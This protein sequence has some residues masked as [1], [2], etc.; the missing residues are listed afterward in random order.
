M[1]YE[2]LKR[3]ARSRATAMK[4]ISAVIVLCF[5]LALS[6]LVRITPA[7]AVM[8]PTLFAFDAPNLGGPPS[9]YPAVVAVIAGASGN[10]YYVLRS[11]GEVDAFGAT[12][13]GSE[14]TGSLPTGT[15]ATGMTLDSATGG[16]WVV[17]SSGTVKGFNAPFLGEPRIP[18]GGWGQYPAAVAIAA[19]PTGDGYFILRANGAIDPYGVKGH[20]SLKG[21]LVYGAIAPVVAVALAVDPI[22][23]GYWIATSTG[24]VAN[25]DAPSEGSPFASSKGNYDGVPV[26]ALVANSSGT[27]YYVLR[28]NGAIDTY[29]ATSHGSPAAAQTMPAG[30]FASA[31]AL[32]PTTGG[33]Y[34][35]VDDTPYGGYVNPLRDLTSLVPQEV[36]QGVDYCASGPIYAI[37]NGVVA[38]LYSSGWPSGSFISYRLTSGPASGHYVYAAENVTPKVTIGERVT[39]NTVIGVVHDAKTCLETGWADAPGAVEHAAAH[40]E[41]NGKNSTAYGLNFNSLLD[42]LGARPGLP[43][44]FGP[45]GPLPSSWPTW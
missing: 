4:F 18:S 2:S 32:D 40:A 34:V 42:V 35:G 24:D 25:F 15:T 13:Y 45:P 12:N 28:T 41:Y 17:N 44:P 37:G 19:T 6:G 29:G 30:S 26:S 10:G 3:D 11:N 9:T 39:S 8:S 5:A 27:G 33:Y 7:E 23:G 14:A 43:Q 22:T 31:L 36:D 16:Y 21:H 1:V 38:N 20:G